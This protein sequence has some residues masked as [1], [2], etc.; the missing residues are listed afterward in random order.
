MRLKIRV[1]LRLFVS[2]AITS[3]TAYYANQE[4][5]STEAEAKSHVLANAVAANKNIHIILESARLSLDTIARYIPVATD[6]L[7]FDANFNE[8][9]ER[10]IDSNA[11]AAGVVVVNTQGRV[12]A[13]AA[14]KN[15]LGISFAENDAIADFSLALN[16]PQSDGY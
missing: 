3:A 11:Y 13:T 8:V 5:K 4:I 12:V 15:D 10:T 6:E 16:K 9:L 1:A 7:K 14:P 2:I